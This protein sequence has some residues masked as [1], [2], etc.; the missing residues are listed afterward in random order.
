MRA[1]VAWKPGR[2]GGTKLKQL[3][4][5]RC[6]ANAP[7]SGGAS[8]VAGAIQRPQSP[9]QSTGSAQMMQEGPHEGQLEG[10]GKAEAR[11]DCLSHDNG[12][13]FQCSYAS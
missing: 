10:A 1:A 12:T 4:I 9:Q 3:S 7:V 5:I 13:N 2:V 8:K 11:S 6:S